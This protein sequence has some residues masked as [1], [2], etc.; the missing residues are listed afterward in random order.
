MEVTETD[1]P[2]PR[3][4]GISTCSAALSGSLDAAASATAASDPSKAKSMTKSAA[5]PRQSIS[6]NHA[7][8]RVREQIRRRIT[9]V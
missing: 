1:A 7:I 5:L 6:A 2:S 9:R 3:G 8:P 4:D